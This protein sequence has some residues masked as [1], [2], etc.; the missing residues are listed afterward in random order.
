[1]GKGLDIDDLR[2]VYTSQESG[3]EVVAIDGINLHIPANEFVC[4]VG[5]SG[6][7]KTTLLNTIDGS[8]GASSGSIRIDGV[9]VQGPGPDRAMVFQQAS[10]F[11]WRTARDNAAYGLELQGAARAEVE[12]R[13]DELFSVVGLSGYEDYFP[14]QL[15]GGMQQ[16]VNLARALALDPEIILLDE[17]F[18]ALDAQTREFMQSELTR[19]WQ[20]NPKTAIFITHDISEAIFLADRVIVLSSRPGRVKADIKID[21]PRP[22]TIQSKRAREFTAYE[23]EIWDLLHD[24]SSKAPVTT[25][26]HRVEAVASA[27]A[28]GTST[29]TLPSLERAATA[30]TSAPAPSGPPPRKTVANPLYAAREGMKRLILGTASVAVVLALWEIAART[31]AIN[32]AFSSSPSQIARA[33]VMLMGSA[34]FWGDVGVSALELG[35]GFGIA[36]VVG[37][38]VGILVGWYRTVDAI[39][40]PFISG[41]Y[42]TP[43]ISLAPL[44]IVWLGI[45]LMSK[46]ALVTLSAVF[47]IIMNTA[48]GIRTTDKHYAR[49]AR[50][51][52]AN[53]WTLFRTVA[54]PAAVPHI[55]GGLRL[56]AGLGIIGVVVAELIAGNA[57]IGYRMLLAGQTFQVAEMFVCLLFFTAAGMLL[58]FGFGMLERRF[59]A[60]RRA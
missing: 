33:A 12:K 38:V 25:T 6:C 8:V 40:A 29:S 41:L 44:L 43:R 11:P 30:Q 9:P 51:F 49:V 50:S 19:I 31:G 58:S 26:S 18:G 28:A 53:D 24:E 15:S 35:I 21:L 32:A 1:M 36:A 52:G 14:S 23:E 48:T 55:I 4:I 46:V 5:R 56:G 45:G 37:I 54:I 57:G 20:A 27:D 22:R 42:A 3:Y 7:G 13:T 60:W 59:D 17:P 47:P 16:R 10:L 2:V 34:S 39:L